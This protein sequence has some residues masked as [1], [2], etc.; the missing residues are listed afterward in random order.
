M[1]YAHSRNRAGNRH[2]LVEHLR[3]VSRL[4]A[5]LAEPLG[6]A[7]SARLIGLW[8][9]LGKFSPA[10]Q[11]Y[12]L[13]CEADPEGGRR[14]PD[15]KAA[16]AQ[17]AARHLGP[18]ALAIQGHHGG[19]CALATLQAWLRERDGDAVSDALARARRALPDL[20]PSGRVPLPPHVD[21]SRSAAEL[22]LRL[23]FSALVDADYLDT[24]AHFTAARS[25]QRGG[26]L[27]M[28]TL[29][30]RYQRSQANLLA[31]TGQVADAR[32][33]VYDVRREVYEACLTSAERPPGI[34]RL[35]VPT[36]GGKT[37]SGMGFALRHAVHHGLQRVV[38][39]VPFVSITEQTADVYREIF[40]R[41]D[42]AEPAVLEHHS[43]ARD[44]DESGDARPSRVWARLAAEN[45]D[46]P[47]VVTTTVQLLESLFANGT[48]RCR[49]LHRLAR[50]VVIL[51]EAQT[52]PSHLL[53]PI[54][55]ALSQLAAHYGTTIVISTATQPA[56]EAIP[57]F[58]AVA[59]T[60]I[61]PQHTRHFRRL[62]RVTYEWRTDPALGWSEIADILRPEPQA[63]AVLNTK[64]DAVALLDALGD[65]DALHLSTALCGAHRRDVIRLVRERLAAGVPCRLISTQVVEAGVDL[66]FPF[67]LRALGP[68][69]AIIQTAGRCNRE[70]RAERGRV[71]IVRPIE[72]ALPP[73]SYTTATGVTRALL[74]RGPIDTDDP[75]TARA[76]F[77]QVF[78]SVPTDRDGI[79]NLRA[80]LDYPEVARR[81]RMIDEDTES[82]VVP[83]G[84]A[85]ERRRQADL[86]DQLRTGAPDARRVLRRLQPYLVAVR[87]REAERE[88]QRGRI[89]PIMPGLGEWRGPYDPVRGLSLDQLVV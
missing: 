46:A 67:A 31:A 44:D 8:H 58:S 69:D 28:Q 71:V 88:R 54:L 26:H 45:W 11:S 48:A 32:R 53:K 51:D 62:E 74:G 75:A 6:A 19:L 60:E 61:V 17:M 27:P 80:S 3:A 41:A 83:Y 29:W 18:V 22:F 39:A 65:P 63:L 38:V 12:L 52:L 37:R 56:F 50:S 89:A 87:A 13:A 25:A 86:I 4:A 34:F 1:V 43:G 35:T 66:D 23:L 30:E 59:S 14:G 70:G 7:E 21:R 79:Q 24:E 72:G 36:G 42:D 2:D 15:H 64:G 33:E 84:S 9:D 40:T 47:I 68:L 20:E 10:F 73:G 16:G 57:E 78:Q 82:V 49:K 76:Y 81:F 5:E 77:Q 85:D 55:D